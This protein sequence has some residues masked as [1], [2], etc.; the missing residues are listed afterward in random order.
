MLPIVA[1][2]LGSGRTT[3]LDNPIAIV[4]LFAGFGSYLLLAV[5]YVWTFQY[6]QWDER[7]NLREWRDV[8]RQ[9]TIVDLQRWLGDACVEAYEN[10]EP[11]MEGKADKSGKALWCL[12]GE[13]LCL[14]VAVLV[15]LV[16]VN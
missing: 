6:G 12:F 1:G 15:P 7:P 13:V 9:F 11:P 2:F 8:S 5:F 10:N 14:S 4:A 3:V 16:P